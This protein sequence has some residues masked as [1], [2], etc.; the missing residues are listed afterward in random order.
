MR[1]GKIQRMKTI[2]PHL[3]PL[4]KNPLRMLIVLGN[5]C[6]PKYG[7]RAEREG[8]KGEGRSGGE[9]GKRRRIN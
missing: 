1:V 8:R 2:I 5:H 4:P 9:R 6:I 7:V 3:P